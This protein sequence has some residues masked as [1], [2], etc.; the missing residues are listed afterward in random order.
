MEIFTNYPMSEKREDDWA[1]LRLDIQLGG[2]ARV[3]PIIDWST[4]PPLNTYI[5]EVS[6]YPG[7]AQNALHP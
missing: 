4:L 1:V 6:G 2:Y 5:G 3:L 7:K